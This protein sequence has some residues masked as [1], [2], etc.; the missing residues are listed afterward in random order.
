MPWNPQGGGGGPWGGGGNNGG[1]NGNSPWGGRGPGGGQGP[2]PDFDEIIRRGQEKLKRAMP[3]GGRG[4]GGGQSLAA[5]AVV[6]LALWGATG[7]YKVDNSELGVVTRFGK[8]VDTTDEGLRYHLPFP[9]ESVQVIKVTQVRQLN[10]GFRT[11]G[12]VRFDRAPSSGRDVPEESRMLTGDENI[13]ETDFTVFWLIKD[14]G[15]VLFNIKDPEGTVKVAAESAMRD[16]IGRN[17]I[18]AALS[19]KREAIAA[20]AKAELQRLLDSYDSGILITQVQLQKVE[21]PSAVIDAFN[22]VQRARADQERARNEA[23]AYRNDIIP[24]ARG[25]VERL[26]QE[27]EA[28]KEQVVNQAEGETKR[29]LALYNAYRQSQDVTE[30]RLYLETMETVLKDTPKVILDPASKGQGV[31]PYLPLPALKSTQ[32]PNSGQGGA[33]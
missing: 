7:F 24:R 27:A 31:V 2:T 1:G 10:L 16:V 32:Q 18:Q 4:L 29:F 5:I 30:R 33:R 11:A 9:V 3:G 14:P 17:P 26:V 23:E 12:D 25:E 19:D 20:A 8:W 13:V 21:P 28:Y 6:A 22:D 15:K